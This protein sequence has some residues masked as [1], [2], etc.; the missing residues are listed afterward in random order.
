MG[1]WEMGRWEWAIGIE[2]GEMDLMERLRRMAHPHAEEAAAE[3]VKLRGEN[4]VLRERMKEMLDEL[5]RGGGGVEP[6]APPVA[7]ENCGNCDNLDQGRCALSPPVVIA[8]G[9]VVWPKVVRTDWC[10]QWVQQS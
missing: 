10:A 6:A 9:A 5:R 1:K 3:I 4:K 2:V 7:S 8:S